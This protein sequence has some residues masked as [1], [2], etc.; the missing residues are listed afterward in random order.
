ML[1]GIVGFMMSRV[2]KITVRFRT[3]NAVAASCYNK[4]VGNEAMRP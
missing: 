2:H 4:I 1:S 3:G